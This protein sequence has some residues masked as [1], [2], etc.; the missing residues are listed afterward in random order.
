MLTPFYLAVSWLLTV[1]YQLFTQTAVT[2]ITVRLDVLWPAAATW[3]N[4]NID[5]VVFIYAFTWIFV[6]SSVI[7][8]MLL[9]KGRSVLL[10]YF[11]C[12]LIAILAFSIQDLLLTFGGVNIEDLLSTAI[13]LNNSIV[14]GLYLIVP[15]IVMLGIDLRTR[16]NRQREEAM[17]RQAPLRF[18]YNYP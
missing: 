4:T 1:T 11:V 6:L 18:E 7:P 16:K 13:F 17:K 15:F 12:L 10:Q 14:A 2:T 3:L 9:G 5:L 8:G